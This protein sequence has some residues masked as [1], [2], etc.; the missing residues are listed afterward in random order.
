MHLRLFVLFLL[1]WTTLLKAQTIT[2]LPKISKDSTATEINVLLDSL[3]RRMRQEFYKNNFAILLNYGDT[4]LSLAQKVG[5]QNRALVV[6]RYIGNTFARMNDTVRAKKVLQKNLQEAKLIKDSIIIANATIDLGN[7]YIVQQQNDK[8]LYYYKMAIPLIRKQGNARSAFVVHNN[9]AEIYLNKKDTN[10][11]E[12]HIDTLTKLIADNEFG[13]LLIAAYHLLKGRLYLLKNK[14]DD[15][16]AIFKENIARSENANYV[17]GTHDTYKYYM[18]ALILKKDYEQLHYV[19]QKYDILKDEK[20]EIEKAKALEAVTSKMNVDQFKQELKAKNLEN[21]LN[22]QTAE[23]SKIFLYIVIFASL[24]LSTF[25]IILLISVRKRKELVATLREKNKQ[26]LIAKQKTEELSKVKSK[27]LS[28][29]SHELRTPLYGIIGISSILMEDIKLKKHSEDINSLKFSADY[30]LALINDLL[31]LNKLDATKDKKLEH[32][33]FQPRILISN[34]VNSFEFM[35]SQNNNTFDIIIDEDIPTFIMGDR[36]K[37]SQILMNLIGNACKFTEEGTITI[38]VTQKIISGGY[39]GLN[40]RISDTGIGISEEKQ[41]TI[42]DEFTQD[43][44]K[45]NFAG[46]GLGLAIVK[47]LLDLHKADIVLESSPDTGTTFKF[48]I[49]YAISSPEDHRI[50][51]SEDKIDKAIAGSHILVVDDNRINQLVTRKILERNGY[52]CSIVDNG[53]KA[54]DIVQKEVFDLILMD[55]NM[56]V[57]NGLDATALIRKAN[58]KTPIIAL[59]AIDLEKI[60][61]NIYTTGIN[62]VVIKPYDV[63]VFLDTLKRNFVQ[64]IKI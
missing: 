25:I 53:K 36:V 6:S 5:D 9:V 12:A 3:E 51:E 41:K 23:R 13:A 8:A 15:A 29:I 56:P 49:E 54:V 32:H 40:F 27:F 62:D 39:V 30:L 26:Y 18:E 10:N 50:V 28:T 34:I 43:T 63:N 14:P 42:F 60:K 17:D 33:P 16:I 31:H 55:I 38:E 4:A 2:G 61:R 48:S 35:R 19:R 21:E 64:T 46:T 22:R 58:I 47:K 59:T 7:L 44:N 24:I 1:L 52:V 11:A 57:M 37:L 45:T 20:F